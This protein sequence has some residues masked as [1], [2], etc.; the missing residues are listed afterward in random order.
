[1][2]KDGFDARRWA[3]QAFSGLRYASYLKWLAALTLG[4]A[5]NRYVRG[6]LGGGGA[7]LI[8]SGLSYGYSKTLRELTE[9]KGA[10]S[11]RSLDD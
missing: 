9:L 3:A 7:M 11:E 8:C 2:V 4:L 6:D 1:M 10:V 5:L